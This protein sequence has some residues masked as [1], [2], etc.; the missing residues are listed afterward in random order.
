MRVRLEQV[1]DARETEHRGHGEQALGDQSRVVDWPVDPVHFPA[2]GGSGSERGHWWATLT[3]V[4]R[5]TPDR[6]ISQRLDC[7]ST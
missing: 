7:N 1:D 5:P 3:A 4:P 2:E 6:P